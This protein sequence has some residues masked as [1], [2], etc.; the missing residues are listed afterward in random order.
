MLKRLILSFFL[1]FSCSVSYGQ[2]KSFY[3]ENNQSKSNKKEK[4]EKKEKENLNYNNLFFNALKQK[5]LE[6]YEHSVTLFE[7]CIEK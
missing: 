5:S 1:V 3:P 7:K 4:K 6:N 2:W